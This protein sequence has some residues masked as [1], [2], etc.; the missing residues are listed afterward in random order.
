MTNLTGFEQ[1]SRLSVAYQGPASGSGYE[2]WREG[3]CRSFCQLDAEPFS[4]DCIDCRIDFAF[5]HSL[6]LATP[7]GSSARF[8]RTRD[9]LPDGCDDLVL[10]TASRGPVQVT[11][12]E[13]T[14]ELASSQACLI[15]MS[16]AVGVALS[17]TARFTATRTPRD[18]L[19]QAAPNAEGRL[20]Q[21]LGENPA[22]I[23]MVQRYFALCNEVVQDLDAVGQQTAAQ[24]L[25]ELI[26]LLLRPASD[27]IE[28]RGYSAARV[29][30]L[31]SE[32][33]KRLT[34]STLTIEM[35]AQANG[36]SP[37]QAQRLFAQ[38]GVTFTE[39]VLEQR[40]ALAHRLLLDPQNRHRK[41]SDIAYAAGF[42]DLSYFNRVFRKQF[43][44]TPSE[45][46]SE[47][48]YSQFN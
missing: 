8:I 40:L 7:T 11:K 16:A 46:R 48:K 45:I 15:E 22:L 24:H 20:Y 36:L 1:A 27:L 19:L 44:I 23:T 35:I 18:F 29:D 42:G 26:G 14:V 6:T 4:S 10:I 28:R 47:T 39:F 30:L 3:I 43:G 34:R 32:V 5:V 12:G 33:L 38:S 9:L 37:R 41:V 31:K 21:P 25:I 13:Q 17:E 2:R